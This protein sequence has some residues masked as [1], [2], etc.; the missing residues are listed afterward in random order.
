MSVAGKR[1]VHEPITLLSGT[2]TLPTAR[3]RSE[4]AINRRKSTVSVNVSL[5]GVRGACL[6]VRSCFIACSVWSSICREG[7]LRLL[8]GASV[9]I[10]QGM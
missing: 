7:F 5:R 6:P 4:D 8:G 1:P 3:A 10:W 9:W 2:E